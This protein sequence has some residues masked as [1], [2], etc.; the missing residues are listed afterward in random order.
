MTGSTSALIIIPIVTVLTLAAWIALV[1]YADAHPVWRRRQES[2]EA[3]GE[4]ADTEQSAET[5]P[6]RSK[7]A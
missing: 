2:P 6:G 4:R 1:F 5:P 3:A 7:A